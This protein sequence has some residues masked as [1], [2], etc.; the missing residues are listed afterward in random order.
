MG[1]LLLHWPRAPHEQGAAWPLLLYCS[2]ATQSLTRLGPAGH[3]DDIPRLIIYKFRCTIR[4][5]WAFVEALERMVLQQPDREER[6]VTFDRV[7]LLYDQAR[8]GY[9]AALFDAI[10]A[11]AGVG[12]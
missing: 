5:N 9:P 6:R 3:L 10:A 11:L 8:P 7:A 12:P 1:I 4:E 2:V